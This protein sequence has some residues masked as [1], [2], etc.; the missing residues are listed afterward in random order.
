L[1]A[2]VDSQPDVIVWGARTFCVP[3]IDGEVAR[4]LDRD[5]DD[6]IPYEE[7]FTYTLDPAQA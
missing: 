6:D 4:H 3:S 2:F 5:A 1:P 7:A